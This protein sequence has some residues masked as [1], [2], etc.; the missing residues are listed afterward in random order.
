[1][2][3]LIQNATSSTFA[4]MS[5]YEKKLTKY[6]RVIFLGLLLGDIFYRGILYRE[7]VLSEILLLQTILL[8]LFMAFS[9]YKITILNMPNKEGHMPVVLKIVKSILIILL[10]TMISTMYHGKLFYFVALLPI[11]Y[12][13][14]SSGFKIAV[15][16]IFLSWVAQNVSQIIISANF[17]NKIANNFD[18][19]LIYAVTIT[20]QYVVFAF[21]TYIWGIIYHYYLES[22]EEKNML[23]ES[24]GEKYVQLD[25]A[26]KEIQANYDEIQKTNKQ[27][28]EIN[29][30]LTSSIAE[31][32]TLQQISQAITSIFDMNELLKFVNDVII[33]VMGAFHST[34]ALCHGRHNRL[35]VQI[36]SIYNKKDLAIVSD[37]INSDVLKPSIIEGRSMI[38]NDV[39]EE[40]YPFTKGRNIKSLVCVPFIAKGKILGIVLIEHRIK[41]AFNNDHVR[42]LEIISQQV[43]IAIENARLYQ[44][45]QDLARLDGLTGA[46]NRLFFQEKLDEEFLKAQEQQYDL[47][48]M[49]ID[50]DNFK[51]YNDTYGHIFGDMILKKMSEYI[52]NTLRK[53]DIFARYGGEEFAVL[54]PRTALDQ[55][56]EKAEEIRKNVSEMTFTNGIV[57]ANITICIGVSNFP[58]YSSNPVELIKTA[59]DALY[60]AKNNGRNLACSVKLHMSSNSL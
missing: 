15:P 32:F 30:K 57:S 58:D 40:D 9:Y 28:K 43:S 59:D 50:I 21:F 51:K 13:S 1:L 2:K 10:V 46:Y 34:I 3:F 47:S 42:L 53:E 39:N 22:E 45:L 16:Y 19:Y 26:K 20:L 18:N 14:L 44:Q 6:E 56:Y 4:G 11:A 41:E 49:I 24:L 52:M 48:F 27:L 29:N 55:A 8:L 38:D 37:Y 36:S 33:G 25:Q 54:M 23:I 60:V 31:L 5:E 12:T 35:K 17:R 7:A